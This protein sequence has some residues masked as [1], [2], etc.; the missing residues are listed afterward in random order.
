[1]VYYDNTNLFAKLP[2]KLAKAYPDA[3]VPQYQTPLSAGVDLHAYLPLTREERRINP[4]HVEIIEAHHPIVIYPGQRKL[5]E[6]G[7]KM[8][9]PQGYELQIRPRS[10]NAYKNGITVLNSPG[11][12]D[13]DYRGQIGVLI[14]NHG[15]REFVVKHGDR[16][17]QGVFVAIPQAAFEIV[18]KLDETERG[19]GA[20][21]HTGTEAK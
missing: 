18:D 16:I 17:A 1:M 8:A 20:Y 21:G 7:L 11:T 9:I 2:V 12:I 13:S 10:G 5:I 15:E 19:E 3:I 6:T 14:I 4:G